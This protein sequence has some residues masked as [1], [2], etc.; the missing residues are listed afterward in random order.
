MLHVG[1]RSGDLHPGGLGFDLGAADGWMSQLTEQ[2]DVSI[3]A[4][5]ELALHSWIELVAG[6]HWTANLL[7]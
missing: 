3:L 4:R 6:S 5:G 7:E 1:L 2:A